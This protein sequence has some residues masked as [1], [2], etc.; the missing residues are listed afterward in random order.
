MG[1]PN[2]PDALKDGFYLLDIRPGYQHVQLFLVRP[3]AE[4][5]TTEK[6]ETSIKPD[7]SKIGSLPLKMDP[8]DSS[9]SWSMGLSQ[10]LKQS[11]NQADLP[12]WVTV[13]ALYSQTLHLP[14]TFSTDEIETAL[15]SE[16][17]QL[18]LF[19][20]SAPRV[21]WYSL[22]NDELYYSALPDVFI[23]E[24]RQVISA[25][26]R[27]LWAIDLSDAL[28]TEIGQVLPIQPIK[29]A[30]SPKNTTA[31]Q[32]HQV[33]LLTSKN[34]TLSH[35][36]RTGKLRAL[37]QTPYPR[38]MDSPLDDISQWV[39]AQ[40]QDNRERPP[41]IILNRLND[42]TLDEKS[43]TTFF[44]A[45]SDQAMIYYE[46]HSSAS[47]VHSTTPP[48]ISN[49]EA[50]GQWLFQ[51]A[52]PSLQPHCRIAF[53]DAGHLKNKGLL[54]NPMQ[55]R[56]RNL[57]RAF[58]FFLNVATLVGL[59]IWG[60]LLF[61]INQ[62][63]E[64]RLSH[65]SEEI[66]EMAGQSV[67]YRESMILHHGLLNNIATHNALIYIKS[68]LK[69]QLTFIGVGTNSKTLQ[70]S[71]SVRLKLN[72]TEVISPE[73]W[74][75]LKKLLPITSTATSK[76]I[77]NNRA[78]ETVIILSSEPIEVGDDTMIGNEDPLIHTEVTSHGH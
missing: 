2:R 27:E 76:A 6:L 72:T 65:L 10:F 1:Q 37:K 66:T 5:P 77:D 47:L 45:R 39:D 21:R 25:L 36:S 18:Y 64:Q 68:V 54:D 12:V 60:G 41:L 38:Q 24:L 53:Y 74:V 59:M 73:Q 69:D 33:L 32:A 13:P 61:V 70:S 7:V 40:Q 3:S 67:A 29:D 46:D 43:V 26:H 35:I 49:E 50:L 16:A 20:Q 9:M 34:V 51:Q 11:M 44:T 55:A 23:T 19:K 48:L 57:V 31:I 17:E 56:Y 4:Q 58:L 63:G 14:S 15:I 52:A 30:S 8:F 62:Q 75:E 28:F 71:P 42:S 22:P 78:F